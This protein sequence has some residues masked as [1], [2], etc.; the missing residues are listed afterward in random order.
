MCSVLIVDDDP[1]IL[2]VVNIILSQNG[3]HVKGFSD[4]D[5]L[6]DKIV[7]E[8][9]DILLLDI[10]LGKK[11]GRNICKEIKAN[12]KKDLKVIL[13]SAN[14]TLKETALECN[15]DDFLEKPFEIDELLEKVR[16]L[17]KN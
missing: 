9:P 10:R 6:L 16:R 5:D 17:C 15:A 8:K 3:Y 11:D 2:N 4:G 7:L 12:W 14:H 1:G 13:F